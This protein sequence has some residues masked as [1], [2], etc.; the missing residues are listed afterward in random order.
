MAQ[1][2]NESIVEFEKNRNQLMSL[3]TQKQQL[4]MQLSVLE[5]SL[6]ELGK[7]SEKKVYKAVGAIL[8]LSDVDEVKK[9]LSSQKET[10]DLRIKSFQ[11]QE[12]V[13]MEKL[14]KLKHSIESASG[15]PAE[16][17]KETKKSKSNN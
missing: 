3:S 9:D 5:K 11:K 13:L 14:N 7:T 4:Q 8:L 6:E 15:K 10:T 12:D 16:G 17:T 1:D 2:V